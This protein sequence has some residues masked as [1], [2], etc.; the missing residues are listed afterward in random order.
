MLVRRICRKPP[1]FYRRKSLNQIAYKQLSQRE[2]TA[3][4][5]RKFN[6]YQE[7]KRCWRKE[8]GVWVLKNISFTEQWSDEDYA[9]L[10]SCLR[11]TVHMGGKV[12]GAFDGCRLI[13]FSSVEREPFGSSLQYLQLS[14]LH[15]SCESRGCGVGRSLFRKA[16]ESA[17][18][19]G[20]KKLYLSA[21]SSEE[22]Q[23]FYRRMGCT[24]AEEYNQKPADAEPCDCQM[25]FLLT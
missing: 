3:S 22:S 8:D 1:V 18:S 19:L 14:S 24:E 25:E 2:I 20:A 10:V 21:H 6:R 12:A 9:F 15:V 4:L 17:K 7:V 23:A 5:F 13:G 16:C 11:N